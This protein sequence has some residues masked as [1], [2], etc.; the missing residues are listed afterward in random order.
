MYT[1]VEEYRKLLGVTIK[2]SPD[3]IKKAYRH[4]AKIFHPDTNKS[5]KAHQIFTQ[6]NE[7]YH[8]L[9]EYNNQDQVLSKNITYKKT[10][11]DYRKQEAQRRYNAFKQSDFYKNDIAFLII[12]EHLSFLFSIIFISSPLIGGVFFGLKGM[13]IGFIITLSTIY[14]WTSAIQKRKSLNFNKLL[15]ALK[16]ILNIKQSQ[17]IITTILH[18]FLFL[19]FTIHTIIN[20]YS[21]FIGLLT[22]I[23]FTFF[24]SRFIIKNKKY[25]FTQAYFIFPLLFNLL[26]TIN[27]IFSKNTYQETYRFK[28]KMLSSPNSH[29]EKSTYIILENNA[30]QNHHYLKMFYDFDRMKNKDSITYYFENGLFNFKV[31]KNYKFNG[32]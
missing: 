6:L 24:I 9:I 1:I 2:S 22:Y 11:E 28:H 18:L 31:L 26:F 29:K 30:Y 19:K 27:Y 5:P 21:F 25:R 20:T 3:E 14:L 16:R 10:S 4:K 8:Y 12:F 17:I 7:A 32:E 23:F 13:G 15:K